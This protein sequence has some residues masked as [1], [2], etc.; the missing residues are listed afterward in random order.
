MSLE[1]HRQL[2]F[3]LGV[4]CEHLQKVVLVLFTF[5]EVDT[6]CKLKKQSREVGRPQ[7]L[8]KSIFLSSNADPAHSAALSGIE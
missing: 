2:Y 5:K 3:P 4:N 1:V 8:T 7:T 6:H